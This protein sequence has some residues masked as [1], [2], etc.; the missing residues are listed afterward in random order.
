MSADL[1]HRL[2]NKEIQVASNGTLGTWDNAYIIPGHTHECANPDYV[3]TPIGDSPYGFIVCQRKIPELQVDN[4]K[5]QG[6]PQ[7]LLNKNLPFS[8]LPGNENIHYTQS[9]NLYDDTPNALPSISRLGGNPLLLQNRRYPN[10][11]H[12]QGVN[13]YRDCTR[14]RGIGIENI[15]RYPGEFG[16]EENKW[17]FSTPPPRFDIS[18][19]VQPYDLWRRE[20]LRLDT[21]TEKQIQELEKTHKYVNLNPVF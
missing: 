21:F 15:D 5:K 10:Q 4:P 18:M 8:S 14:Y 6:T 16:Y 1:Y 2:K 20:Q 7:A 19:G 12:N 13:Y 17:Y 11:A 3:S 9:F